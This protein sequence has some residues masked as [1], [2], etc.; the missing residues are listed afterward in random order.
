MSKV[1]V[2]G[3]LTQQ[4]RVIVR[5]SI[6]VLKCHGLKASWGGKALVSLHFHITVHHQK[7]YGQELKQSRNLEVGA[8]AEAMEKCC[9]LDFPS[10]LAQ[11][12]FL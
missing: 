7:K 4:L 12:V 10:W 1:C 2:A 3:E 5:V 9:L 6:T 11:S 8:D